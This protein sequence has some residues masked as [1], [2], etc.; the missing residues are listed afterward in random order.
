MFF[1]QTHCAICEYLLHCQ[2]MDTI[3]YFPRNTADETLAS[4]QLAETVSKL[5]FNLQTSDVGATA[6]QARSFIRFWNPVGCIVNNDKLPAEIF[7]GIPSVFRHRNP[8]T[9]PPQ[10]TL[11]A[12][13]E[14]AIASMAARELLRLNLASYCFVPEP[15]NEYWSQERERGFLLA[16]DV[17]FKLKNT[18]VCPIRGKV[19]PKILRDI[20][21]WL[22]KL[23][24]PIGVFAANDTTAQIV[25][26]A[27]VHAKL[28]IPD[29]VAL[30]GVDNIASICEKRN[31]SISSIE[32]EQNTSI[33]VQVHALKELLSHTQ[34]KAKVI[35][36]APISI[37]RRASTMRFAQADR[38]VQSAVEL[39][40]R[41]AC[42]GLTASDVIATFNCSRRMAEM[43][44]RAV[45]GHS[46]LDAIRD[47]RLGKV[48]ELLAAG[49][50]KAP[51]IAAR[52]GY[53]SWSSVYR[54]LR[55][56]HT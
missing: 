3:L 8:K 12:Y 37:V 51:E 9:V 28:A 54:L 29:D 23:P 30:L 25:V 56:R 6:A 38:D 39:I 44:F 48:R 52:C 32:V 24:K 34:R 10:S 31:I 1:A 50:L 55:Q 20:S 16:M 36:I 41:R 33:D 21:Q 35:R 11:F 5:G 22:L 13:D 49:K 45:T 40:R 2:Q 26:S 46:I 7:R 15:S 4:P 53:R 27:C 47:V 19:L 42:D 18:T 14:D 43:R 17:N